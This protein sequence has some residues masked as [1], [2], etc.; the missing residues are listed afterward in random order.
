ML[1]NS[2]KVKGYLTWVSF[3]KVQHI[4]EESRVSKYIFVV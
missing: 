1:K 3:I 2:V 4:F